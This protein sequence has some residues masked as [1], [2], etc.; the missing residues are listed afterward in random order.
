MSGTSRYQFL[1][2]VCGL[3]ALFLTI[4]GMFEKTFLAVFLNTLTITTGIAVVATYISPAIKG[5]IEDP[6]DRTTQ[7]ILGITLMFISLILN[8]VGLM[9]IPAYSGSLAFSAIAFLIF[10]AGVL[11]LSPQFNNQG[12]MTK[13]MW[14]V[15][16][17]I[18]TAASAVTAA[19]VTFNP[20]VF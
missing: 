10:L 13:R 3:F 4:A 6:T 8:R 9:I 1:L 17:A 11:H 12:R 20:H 2:V 15:M 7:L 14:W 16:S 19:I 18:V 5:T